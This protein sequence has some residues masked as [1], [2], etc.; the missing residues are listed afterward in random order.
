M[1]IIKWIK[2][3]FSFLILVSALTGIIW[4]TNYVLHNKGIRVD[5]KNKVKKTIEKVTSNKG[6]S[7]LT[8]IYNIYLNG[9]KHK[10]KI[11]YQ[12]VNKSDEEQ[13]VSLYVY[14]DGKNTLEREIVVL[15]NIEE[16]DI[17]GVFLLEDIGP[18]IEINENSFKI[19]NDG[20]SDYLVLSMGIV[21]DSIQKYYYLLDNNGDLMN[22]VGI[23]ISDSAKNYV[24]VNG[25][26]F[27][28]YYDNENRTLAKIK[29][30]NIYALEEKTDKKNLNLV[31]YKYY[32]DDGKLKKEKIVTFEDIMIKDKNSTVKE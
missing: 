20:E 10:L 6:K 29:D 27:N 21:Q 17:D 24:E 7:N 12:L 16:M 30:N 25:E 9:E 1:K 11:E 18:N 19:L 13:D 2:W 8:E 31:E 28:N 32:F 14:F 5:V 26:V 22:D 4:G 23:L 3:I 15:Q